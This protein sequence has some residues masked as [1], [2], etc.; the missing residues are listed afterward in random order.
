[1]SFELFHCF[2]EF[3][4]LIQRRNWQSLQQYLNDVIGRRERYNNSGDRGYN[5]EILKS[6]SDAIYC[7]REVCNRNCTEAI[8]T[9]SLTALITDLER[10]RENFYSDY[11]DS[12]YGRGCLGS[13]IE[14][15]RRVQAE[16]GEIV[17]K[18]VAE[19]SPEDKESALAEVL[20][21]IQTRAIDIARIGAEFGFSSVVLKELSVDDSKD[22]AYT[23][24]ASFFGKSQVNDQ[25]D[26]EK[27]S[28]AMRALLRINELEVIPTEEQQ[29]V[30]A[31]EA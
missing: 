10:E 4:Y 18:P 2:G 14:D 26:P 3:D 17:E 9:Q 7:A 19:R 21:R 5:W 25:S 27:C 15:I 1:M 8:S 22:G 24:R 11:D 23:I 29:E 13:V 12:G 30:S 16:L 20:Q 31:S 28:G 6:L